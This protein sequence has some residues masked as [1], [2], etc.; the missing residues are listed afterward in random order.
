DAAMRV[1]RAVRADDLLT[2]T[3]RQLAVYRALGV[4]AAA[5]PAFA[6]V[7]LVLA[8]GGERLAKRRR[9]V[10]IAALRARGVA[11]EAVVGVLAA[12]AGLGP[13][14]TRVAA[15]ELVDGFHLGSVA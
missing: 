14:G 2:S 15:R 4:S 5:V 6:H 12:S 1:T 8:P 13:A 9:P 11:P 3:P 10:S 7:P